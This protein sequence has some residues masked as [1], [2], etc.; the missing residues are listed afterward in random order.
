MRWEEGTVR[1]GCVDVI[2][3]PWVV[4]FCGFS[5]YPAVCCGSSDSGCSFLIVAFVVFAFF[6]SVCLVLGLAFVAACCVGGEVVAG[7][8][9]SLD[10]GVMGV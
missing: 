3:C 5:A 6:V 7:E 4:L 9:G 1:V 10:H 8:A 2:G